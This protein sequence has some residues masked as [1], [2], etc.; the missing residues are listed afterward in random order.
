MPNFVIDYFKL[1]NIWKKPFDKGRLYFNNQCVKTHY[2][3]VLQRLAITKYNISNTIV[4]E[5]SI[6][7]FKSRL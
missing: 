3:S 5:S 2:I 4:V 1:I 6:A 7:L